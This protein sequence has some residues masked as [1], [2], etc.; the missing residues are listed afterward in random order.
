MSVVA[1]LFCIWC[2]EL[3]GLL[4]L[5][6]KPW[7]SV[8][9]HTGTWIPSFVHEF[10][11]IWNLLL[12]LLLFLQLWVPCSS[13]TIRSLLWFTVEL[14]VLVL[15][16]YK[17][18]GCAAVGSQHQPKPTLLKGHLWNYSPRG[19]G[20][21]SHSGYQILCV[22]DCHFACYC[23]LYSFHS[24]VSLVHLS[25]GTVLFWRIFKVHSFSTPQF[26]YSSTNSKKATLAPSF[27]L[28]AFNA[29]DKI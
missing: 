23:C 25:F 3:L 26:S 17:G 2:K 8:H 14:H 13:R 24:S 21:L 22:Q 12:L 16:Q 4:L 29:Q 15:A 11:I 19:E 27:W 1:C 5:L 28:C 7:L 9:W 6:L 20:L 10:H 18:Q